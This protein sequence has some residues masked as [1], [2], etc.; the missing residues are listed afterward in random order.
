MHDLTLVISDLSSGGAQRVLT[1]LAN[2]WV[3][4]GLRLCVV[5]LGAPQTNFFRLD[6]RITRL[7]IGGIGASNS[8]L[9]AVRANLGRI[10]ALRRALRQAGAPT[11]VA[12]I[13]V[14][15]ILTVFAAA[16]L[17]M[18]VIICER[19]DPRRQSL[20]PV[21]DAL[22]RL[23][24]RHADLVTANSRGALETLKA[25]VP[26]RKLAFVPNPLVA[27]RA[28]AAS[29]RGVP[30]ILTVGRLT[31]QK[32]YDILLGAFARIAG[33][34]PD[35]RLALIG[36]GELK[37][38]LRSQA[39]ALGIAGR[40]DWIGRVPDPFPHYAGADIFVLPS[41]F[42]GTPNALLEAM[43]CGL[44]AVVSDASSG[45]LD[46][47]EDGVSGL[48]VPAEDV[49]ALGDA[50]ARLISNP[51]LR[52]R[53]GDAAR[54]RVEENALIRVLAKWDEVLELPPGIT[55]RLARTAI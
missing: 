8:A 34:A 14:V 23:V 39:Q 15:N 3:E 13:G 4:R 55:A 9:A 10:A 32:G 35:W 5:T 33:S 11:V 12:F 16:G 29:G 26:E 21:W 54:T 53:L 44:P 50:L 24:Y 51:S 49:A 42:E 19:N 28:P 22:R 52:R 18:R 47:V 40:I 37:C 48:V 41:R 20:G 2:A 1:A 17:G 7:A 38:A 36:E 25:F 46:C 45:P 31:E 30:T 27:P 6:A 43:S